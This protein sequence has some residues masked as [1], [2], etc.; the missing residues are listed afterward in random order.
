MNTKN[1]KEEGFAE[2]NYPK[3]ISGLVIKI[4]NDWKRFC[5][6]PVRVKEEFHFPDYG[7]RDGFGYQ[8]TGAGKDS[9][10]F[11]E[12]TLDSVAVL[13]EVAKNQG[14]SAAQELIETA[15]L[16]LMAIGGPVFEF[17]ASIENEYQVTGL[18]KEVEKSRN[19]WMLRIIHYFEG[20]GDGSEM[21]GSHADKSGYTLKL[22]E[23]VPGL[24][25]L[26]FDKKGWLELPMKDGHAVIVP[27]LQLQL[28]SRGLIKGLWHRVVTTPESSMNGRYSMVCF[29]NLVETPI[30][31]RE[32]Q[33]YV[34]AK[35]P[36]FNYSLEN[37]SFERLFTPLG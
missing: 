8:R 6:L 31:D 7:N 23:D 13:N 34:Q 33:G 19:Q 28:R 1:L 9:K 36:G 18:S 14:V 25:Y 21:G 12:F 16:L 32:R 11:A 3:E 17:A 35:E 22:Y 24:Q 27:G 10:E 2:I 29:V 5:R 30:F 26:S 15:S 20:S 37:E 4:M